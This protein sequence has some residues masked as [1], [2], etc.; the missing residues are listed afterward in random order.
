[1]DTGDA[2]PMEGETLPILGMAHI[3]RTQRQAKRMGRI[4][5]E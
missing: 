5:E 1:M 2:W 3:P 4:G